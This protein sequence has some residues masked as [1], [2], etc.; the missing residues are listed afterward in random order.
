MTLAG[1]GFVYVGTSGLKY[2]EL[3][4]RGESFESPDFQRV[5]WFS[6]MRGAVTMSP[7]EIRSMCRWFVSGGLLFALIGLGSFLAALVMGAPL[8]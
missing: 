3:I 1:L 5:L 6:T 2:A 7:D 8:W 4:E